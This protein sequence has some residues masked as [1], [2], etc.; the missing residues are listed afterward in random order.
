MFRY[1]RLSRSHVRPG[2]DIVRRPRHFLV[3]RVEPKLAGRVLHGAMELA[4]HV[5]PARSW[6]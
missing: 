1:G 4:Q 3:Y 2:T 6:E 5:D